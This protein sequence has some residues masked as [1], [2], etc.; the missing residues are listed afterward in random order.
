VAQVLGRGS[1]AAATEEAEGKAE[2]GVGSEG[3]QSDED[4]GEEGEEVEDR[5]ALH[6]HGEGDGPVELLEGKMEAPAAVSDPACEAPMQGPAAPDP[7]PSKAAEP[8][9]DLEWLEDTAQPAPAR[10][11]R[12][13]KKGRKG[14]GSEAAAAQEAEGK[15]EGGV[16]SEG[17]QNDDDRGE[18][19]EEIEGRPAPYEDR[20]G[21]GTVELLESKMEAPATASKQSE[22]EPLACPSSPQVG[23]CMTPDHHCA[24]FSLSGRLLFAGGGGRARFGWP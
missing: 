15:V 16:G 4:G 21:D 22:A 19:D 20:G 5:P 13:K 23:S 17:E 2:G 7:L 9:D 12:K 1:G 10:K 8:L 18:E 14:R 11:A 24:T 6:V 3:E